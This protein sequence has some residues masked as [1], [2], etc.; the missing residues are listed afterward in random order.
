MGAIGTNAIFCEFYDLI[1]PEAPILAEP[2]D[3]EIIIKSHC[4]AVNINY[5][6]RV[7][8]KDIISRLVFLTH[9]KTANMVGTVKLNI[10]QH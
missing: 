7:V 5:S 2:E 4:K 3:D 6:F 8:A 1:V 10:R 9:H